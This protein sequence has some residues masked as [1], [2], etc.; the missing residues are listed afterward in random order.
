MKEVVVRSPMLFLVTYPFSAEIETKQM[1][2]LPFIENMTGHLAWPLVMIVLLIVLRKH[3]G[4][5]ADRIE[6][7]S[8]GGAKFTWKKKLAEGARIID[9]ESRPGFNPPTEAPEPKQEPAERS[10]DDKRAEIARDFTRRRA[11]QHETISRS[12]FG[13]VL[14]GLDEVDKTLFDIGDA[15]GI[16]AASAPSVMHS[17]VVHGNVPPSIGK[18]YDTLRDARNLIAHSATLPDEKEASEYLR[19]TNFLRG[20]L[21]SLKDLTPTRAEREK[22]E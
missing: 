21:Q 4:A 15:M 2:W 8:F 18:L 7:F 3:V 5:L 13:Q 10:P 20:A 1:S 16:D 14:S 12:A 22:F 6:E 19:Q 11:T 9:S 17:L